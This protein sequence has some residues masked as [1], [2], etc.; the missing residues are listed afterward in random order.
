MIAILHNMDVLC[1]WMSVPPV[2]DSA[3]TLQDEM[4]IFKAD[5]RP[6]DLNQCVGAQRH[7]IHC[8]QDVATMGI[9]MIL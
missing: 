9:L 5:K 6:I 1:A 7:L 3:P 2:L 8:V 4:I